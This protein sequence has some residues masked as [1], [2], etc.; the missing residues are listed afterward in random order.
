MT[1]F[2]LF[3]FDSKTFKGYFYSLIGMAFITFGL[4]GL[5]VIQHVA[6]NMK[7]EEMRIAENKIYTILEDLDKQEEVMKNM[8]VKFAAYPEFRLNVGDSKYKE[9]Q[10]LDTLKYY[11]HVSGMAE[12]FFLRYACRDSVYTSDGATT[13]LHVYLKDRV[14]VEQG[15]LDELTD[16]LGDPELGR[17]E[18]PLVIRQGKQIFFIFPLKNYHTSREGTAEYLCI[19]SS[20]DTIQNRVQN[21]VGPIESEL[22]IFYEDVCIF[23][24]P[25]PWLEKARAER[26]LLE[27]ISTEGKFSSSILLNSAGYFSLRNV[28]TVKEAVFLLIIAMILILMA[29]VVASW[30]FR[31]IRRIAERYEKVLDKETSDWD[32]IESMIDCLLGMKE[33]EQEVLQ[34]QYRNLR[35]QVVQMVVSGEYSYKLENCMTLLNIKWNAPF[36]GLIQCLPGDV[37]ETED[38]HKEIRKGIMDL[39]GDSLYLYPYEDEE[40]VWYVLVAAEESYQLE[41]SMELLQSVF[42][43]LEIDKDMELVAK[44]NELKALSHRKLETKKETGQTESITNDKKESG[45]ACQIVEYIKENCTDYNMSLELV[46][47]QFDITTSYLCRII[48]QQ[49]GM[50]YKEYITELRIAKAKDILLENGLSVAEVCTRVGYTNVSNFIRVF[51]KYTGMTPAKFRDANLKDI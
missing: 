16:I 30:N 49:I 50:S 22:A 43:V 24:E 7:Q 4:I 37:N 39:S 48:K 31:P 19:V 32:D 33:K 5:V 6:D 46:A 13:S 11:N 27:G 38:R 8:A 15:C 47:Q 20:T 44:G 2:K 45:V 29:I 17:Q 51:Q 9:I 28:F 25:E 3:H 1:K 34:E 41:E 40:N 23:G 35:E 42:E 10:I 12:H 21:F 26:K 18:N 14:K 36:F